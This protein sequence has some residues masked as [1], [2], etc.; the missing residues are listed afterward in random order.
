MIT[1][2]LRYCGIATIETKGQSAELVMSECL[3]YR[4]RSV[5]RPHAATFL[6]LDG[7]TRRLKSVSVY[8]NSVNNHAHQFTPVT[9]P[10]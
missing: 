6:P 7:N 9:L 10:A 8:R 5:L 1:E 3:D 4:I 2:T